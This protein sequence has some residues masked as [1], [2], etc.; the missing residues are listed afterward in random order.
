[1]K[2][3]KYHTRHSVITAQH[4]ARKMNIGLEKAKQ[5]MREPT[6]KVIQTAVHPITRQYIVYHL[7]LHT[8]RLEGKW[9]S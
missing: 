1:M 3:V 7:D 8:A 9:K 5:T 4:L 6:Q 2:R